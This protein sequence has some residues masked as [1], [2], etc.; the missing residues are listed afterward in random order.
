MLIAQACNTD[1]EMMGR[2]SLTDRARKLPI[3][4]FWGR[5]D[6]VLRSQSWQAVRFLRN[7]E[8]YNTEWEQIEGGH[9]RP[10]P[11]RAWSLWLEVLPKRHH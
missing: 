5:D 10:S 9:F 7:N 3:R 4:I 8:C 11:E 1:V 2:I 6:P